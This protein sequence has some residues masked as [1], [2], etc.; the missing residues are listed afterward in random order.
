MGSVLSSTS[1][2]QPRGVARACILRV[3]PLGLSWSIAHTEISHI[4]LWGFCLVIHTCLFPFLKFIYLYT[5][6]TRWFWGWRMPFS[7]SFL[8]LLTL[9]FILHSSITPV[10]YSFTF[11]NSS[12]LPHSCPLSYVLLPHAHKGTPPPMVF[13]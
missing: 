12:I 2:R 13:F 4:W 7:Y 11:Y 1:D 6:V 5:W 9:P 3:D 10:L 8:F